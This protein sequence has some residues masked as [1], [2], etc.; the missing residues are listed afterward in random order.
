MNAKTRVQKKIESYGHQE[1]NN[2]TY[3]SKISERMFD[4]Q[5]IF[6]RKRSRFRT[7]SNYSYLPSFI[8]ENIDRYRYLIKES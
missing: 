8:L 1:Y 5:D 4:G 6:S 3:L 7:L 2:A